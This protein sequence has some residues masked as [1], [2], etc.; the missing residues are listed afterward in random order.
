MNWTPENHYFTK[1][2]KNELPE[3][4]HFYLV[5]TQQ[6]YKLDSYSEEEYAFDFES[7]IG[8]D[9][10]FFDRSIYYVLRS[11]LDNCIQ[12]SIRITFWDKETSLPIQ[13]LFDRDR[14]FVNSRC[15]EFLAHWTFRN[16]W[17]DNR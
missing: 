15:K 9:Q 16:F 3:L 5:T 12:A 13:K 6:H 10:I 1:L 14:K 7:L 2:N 11:K 17:K 4:I 8:E